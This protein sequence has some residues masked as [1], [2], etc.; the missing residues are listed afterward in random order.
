MYSFWFF[1]IVY[2]CEPVAKKIIVALSDDITAAGHIKMMVRRSLVIVICC[3]LVQFLNIFQKRY[4]FSLGNIFDTPFILCFQGLMF[5]VYPLLGHLA[6]VYL[7]R[8][9]TLKCGLVMILISLAVVSLCTAVSGK[10]L[11]IYGVIIG[12]IVTMEWVCL[13]LMPFS[14]VWINY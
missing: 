2:F 12:G 7:T 8:Y 9:R 4:M 1:H 6:D 11:S 14:L 5:L 3:L 13:K 10:V